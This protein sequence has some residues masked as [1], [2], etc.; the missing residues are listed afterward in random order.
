MLDLTHFN[1]LFMTLFGD[2]AKSN[3]NF[4]L[5]EETKTKVPIDCKAKSTNGI[6][7]FY[8]LFSYFRPI[9]SGY[10]IESYFLRH[11]VAI[12]HTDRN[13]TANQFAITIQFS[14][15]YSFRTKFN[16][17]ILVCPMIILFQFIV[18][19]FFEVRKLF[20]LSPNGID[21]YFRFLWNKKYTNIYNKWYN[22]IKNLE[23]IRL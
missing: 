2:S 9:T 19:E 10:D 1:I 16:L 11:W 5:V 17:Y 18:N 15:L 21:L 20:F 3:R 13:W 7:R 22:K 8:L 12:W 4:F 14:T 6:P 23:L